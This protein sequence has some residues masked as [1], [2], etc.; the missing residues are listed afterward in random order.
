MISD[1]RFPYWRVGRENNLLHNLHP[2]IHRC[3]KGSKISKSK[4]Q[5]H[6]FT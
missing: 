3:I 4:F 5:N 1:Q 6:F 2:S